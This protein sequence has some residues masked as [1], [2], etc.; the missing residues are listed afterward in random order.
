[1]LNDKLPDQAV[2]LAAGLATRLRPITQDMPK[3][4]VP[5]HGRPII[6][7]IFD[8]LKNINIKNVVVNA[9][10]FYEQ[11]EHHLQKY[12]DFNIQISR[13][14]EILETGG[15][16]KQA[17]SFLKNDIFFVINAKILWSNGKI[18]VLKR[19]VNFWDSKKMDALLLL[20][21]TVSAVGY[22]GMGDFFLDQNGL[23]SRR[24]NLQIS[25]FLFTG[26]QLLHPKI[27]QNTPDGFFSMNLIYD[28]LIQD[29]KLYGIRHDGEW[30]HISTPKHLIEVENK[31]L[32]KN[33]SFYG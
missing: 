19:L 1:M 23:V 9:H 5:I 27:F 15:G 29:K 18:N 12:S 32:D 2:I 20:H 16:I 13:E 33:E 22:E 10:Y 30:F 28:K 11:I 25:P 31:F 4:L 24:K 3:A 17:L 7:F 26:I 8:Q 6:D 21:P 14:K